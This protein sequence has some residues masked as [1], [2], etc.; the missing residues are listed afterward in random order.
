[1]A[2]V[3]KKGDGWLWPSLD[4]RLDPINEELFR[5]QC[6]WSLGQ[7]GDARALPVLVTATRDLAHNVRREAVQAL[8]RLDSAEARQALEAVATE[9]DPTDP[10]IAAEAARL[11]EKLKAHAPARTQSVP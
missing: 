8:S 7:I 5:E 2:E 1:M 10:V 4:Q 9:E 3:E 11:L 6:A